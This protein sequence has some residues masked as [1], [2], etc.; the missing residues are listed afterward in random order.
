MAITGRDGSQLSGSIIDSPTA[1]LCRKIISFFQKSSLEF[2][3]S[4]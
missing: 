1:K 2:A 4:A 3:A